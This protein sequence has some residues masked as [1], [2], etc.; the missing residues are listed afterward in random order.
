MTTITVALR[1]TSVIPY[2]TDDS[3]IK[4]LDA[5]C[6][7]RVRGISVSRKKPEY[8]WKL[9]DEYSVCA[10]D[11]LINLSH[12]DVDFH[13]ISFQVEKCTYRHKQNNVRD[14]CT[15]YR[16]ANVKVLETVME[17]IELVQL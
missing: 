3:E 7:M 17:T 8:D 13:R 1:G 11:Q 2:E 15:S 12:T 16:I 10:Y 4:K 9:Y 14:K 5:L 6:E